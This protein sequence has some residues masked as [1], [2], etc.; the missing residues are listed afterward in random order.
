MSRNLYLA[1]NPL[2]D[3]NFEFILKEIETVQTK[4]YQVLS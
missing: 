3:S 1:T 4:D 2:I